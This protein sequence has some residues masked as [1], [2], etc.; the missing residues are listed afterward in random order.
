MITQVDP[1]TALCQHAETQLSQTFHAPIHLDVLEQFESDHTVLRCSVLGQGGLPHVPATIILKQRAF[2]LQRKPQDFDQNLLFRNEWA[3][4]DFL[5]SRTGDV[6]IAPRLYASDFQEGWVALEDLGD[7]SSV[8]QVLYGGDRQA[9]VDALVGMGRTL[10]KLQGITNGCENHFT[11]R[12]KALGAATTLSDSSLDCLSRLEDLHACMA[13]LG[14]ELGEKFD[15]AMYH[16]ESSIHGA[17]ALRTFVH[18]DAGPH[19][20]VAAPGG[21]QLLDFEFAGYA[22]G[23]LDVVCARLAFPPAFRGRV[24]PLEVVRQLEEA[25][26]AE[27]VRQVPA[28]R[29]DQVFAEAIAQAGAHWAFSKL[30]GLWNGYLRERLQEGETR[31]TRDGRS[32]ERS[33]FLR[34]QVFTYLR[35]AQA[36]LE[37]H[38]SLPELHQTLSKIVARLLDIWPDT[39]LLSGY[40]AFGGEPWHYP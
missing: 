36:T 6:R 39:P 31:D 19:N 9:A 28:L 23:L 3:S 4:L 8:Q 2:S 7:H 25:Y 40:P 35:L 20:F 1:F 22:H 16:L 38:D 29:D 17:G 12:Q 21:V 37:E 11:V 27:R 14:L 13:G 26:R 34:M 5:T 18:H 15:L 24:L 10:G 32:P 30:L 33:A